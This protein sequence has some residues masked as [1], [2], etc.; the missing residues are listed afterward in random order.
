MNPEGPNLFKEVGKTLKTLQEKSDTD[1]YVK[2][3]PLNDFNQL[4]QIRFLVSIVH[5]FPLATAAP[6]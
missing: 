2:I 5:P 3:W 4:E 1:E 6:V